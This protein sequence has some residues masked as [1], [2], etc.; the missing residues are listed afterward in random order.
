MNKAQRIKAARRAEAAELIKKNGF[1]QLQFNEHAGGKGGPSWRGRWV[2]IGGCVEAAV[3]Y[4]KKGVVKEVELWWLDENNRRVTYLDS[5]DVEAIINIYS[6]K[7][8]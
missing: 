8:V 2:I 4:T 1:S 6:K 7:V 5:A 3:A